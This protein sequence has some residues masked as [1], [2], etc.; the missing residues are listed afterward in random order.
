MP[1]QYRTN[2]QFDEIL[3]S[4]NNGNWTQAAEQCV[5]YGFYAGDITA[6]CDEMAAECSTRYLIDTL[7]DFIV[8]TQMATE[9]RSLKKEATNGCKT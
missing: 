2:E 7:A 1:K 4:K 3:E 8:L 5:E 6:K 9:L